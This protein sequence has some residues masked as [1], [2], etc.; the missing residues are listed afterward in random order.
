MANQSLTKSELERCSTSDDGSI[1]VCS[2]HEFRNELDYLKSKVDAGAKCITTQ[3]FFD[4]KIFLSFVQQ[5]RSFGITV[6]IIPGILCFSTYD[7]FVRMAKFC[8]SRLPV[9]MLEA[10]E[11]I[12]D[13]ADATLQYAVQWGIKLCRDLISNGF[14][15]LHFYTLNSDKV[16]VPILDGLGLL[17]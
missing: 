1:H 3:M 6:P 11:K 4:A 14:N 16:V 13:D 10:M 2:D 9:G 15:G 12:K 8:K 7:N 5:C 17:E